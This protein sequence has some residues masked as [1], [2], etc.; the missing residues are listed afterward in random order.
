MVTATAHIL[1]IDDE[2][3]MREGCRRALTPHGFHVSTAEHGVEGLRKMREEPFD[4]I[5]LDAMMPGMSGL[6]LLERIRD[7]DPSIICVMITGYATV[8]LAAQAMKQGACDFLP[9]PFTSDELLTVVNRGLEERQ[10]QLAFKQQREQEEEALQLERTRQEIAKLD[11]I[12][13]RFMLVLVHQLRDPAGVIKNYLQLMRA[14]YVDA[15]EWDEYLEKLDLRA[16]QL[17]NML[18]DLL[19]LAHLKE[20]RGSSKLKPVAVADILEQVARRLQ[21]AAQ[22]KGLDFELQIQARPTLLAQPVHLQSLWTNLIDNAI[23]YTPRGQVR[24]TLAEQDGQITGMVTDTGIGVSTEELP[25]IFQEFYRSEA[26]KA[27]VELG[28]GLGLP[29]VDQIVKIYGGTIRV[30]SVPG[31]GSKFI[32][33]LPLV[34]PETGL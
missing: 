33:R 15:D 10:R 34:A 16:G 32:V 26:A 18:D 3:G 9:K 24:V 6:E 1:V 17:L 21:P 14:G 28:T 25:R 2:I 13:S 4:L 5:L 27:E 30:D 31:Q 22:A 23:R 12:E 20:M 7:H 8:D 29:I 19:E 11:A